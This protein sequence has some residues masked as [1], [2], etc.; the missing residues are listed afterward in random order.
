MISEPMTERLVQRID[1]EPLVAPGA[2]PGYGPIFNAGLIHHDGRYHL[3]ARGVRDGYRRNPGSGPRFLDYRS[4]VLLFVSADGRRYEFQ[5]VLAAGGSTPV[6]SYE[7]PRIQQVLSAGR[8]QLMMTYTD[9]PEPDSG[10]PW[11]IGMHRLVYGDGAFHLNRT[12]GRVVGPPGVPDKDAVLFNLHDGRVA[13]LH[14]IQPNIQ[15]AVFDSLEHLSAPGP[16]Y[17]RDHLAQLEDHVI[18]RPA[19]GALGIGAGPPPIKTELGLVLFFHERRA[20]GAYTMKVALLDPDTGRTLSE[21]PDP[22]LEPE[23]PWEVNGDVDRVVF[24]QG[25]HR[26]PDRTIYLTY[27]AADR[28]VGAAVVSEPVLLAALAA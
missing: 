7:D 6:Y 27:G 11:R 28:A 10:L 5:K 2:V 4:D 19:P 21:L 3:F 9:L 23:L 20:D 25:A 8:R 18:L 14:R 12:S 16:T 22:V 17:W 1:S 13:L 26:R 24:V 15:L